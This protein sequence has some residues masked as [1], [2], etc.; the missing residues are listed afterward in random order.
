M[1]KVLKEGI[2]PG[3]VKAADDKVREIVEATLADIEKR[4]D[5]AVRALSV[6]F[7]KWDRDDYRLTP[8]E[9]NACLGEMTR[10]D[11]KDIEFAQEQVRN[12]AQVQKA[13]LLDIEVLV[14]SGGATIN[15][16]LL[17]NRLSLVMSPFGR[18]RSARLGCGPKPCTPVTA[19]RVGTTRRTPCA[20]SP[21]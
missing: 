16:R 6:K 10:Q 4:G 15:G 18:S 2:D 12:F 14:V 20:F 7:D 19:S 8:A 17:A 21:R 9:I 1:A 5:A 11:I 3:I 13:A